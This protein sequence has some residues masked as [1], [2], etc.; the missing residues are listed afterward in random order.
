M[1]E[2]EVR[3]DVEV[4]RVPWNI[5]EGTGYNRTH[6]STKKNECIKMN[7]LHQDIGPGGHKGE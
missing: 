1:C 6:P 7:V 4:D 5:A 2:Q 3:R